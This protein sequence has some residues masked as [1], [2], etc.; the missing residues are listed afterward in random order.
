MYN[1]ICAKVF[2]SICC[3]IIKLRFKCIGVN[4]A[5]NLMITYYLLEKIRKI[6][7]IEYAKYVDHYAG[8]KG[9]SIRYLSVS[10][11]TNDMK[12]I[13]V[14]NL[15]CADEKSGLFVGHTEA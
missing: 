5:A 14:D 3:S 12:V 1:L 15:L 10:P 2:N 6:P 4:V 13:G 8:S 11:R 7:G 9:N